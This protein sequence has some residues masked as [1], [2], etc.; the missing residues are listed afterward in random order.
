[1]SE[2]SKP[3]TMSHASG[4][5]MSETTFPP[6]RVPTGD[7]VATMD[8]QPSVA[9]PPFAWIRD[10]ATTDPDRV[11]AVSRVGTTTYGEL[12]AMV[13]RRSAVIDMPSS[14]LM[15]VPVSLDLATVVELMAVVAAGGVAMPYLEEVPAVE[16]IPGAGDV[17]AVPTSGS[18]GA[19]R[20]VRITA[21]NIVAAV[22]ASRT[23]L[24]TDGSDRWL[25]CL[26]L[27]HVG[28]LSILW[29]S[30]EAGGSIA[31]APFDDDLADFITAS[32]PTVASM[33]PTMVRR[34]LAVDAGC[35]SALRFILV[36]GAAVDPGLVDDAQ[37]HGITL[38][39]TYG[40]T[41]A[42]S[43]IA[44]VRPDAP[45]L[46]AMP[47]EGITVSIRHDESSPDAGMAQGL[48]TIEGASVSPG[49]LGE[50]ERIGPFVT[51]DI[52]WIDDA[53][54]LHI[55]GRAD[56]VVISG[57]ENVSLARVSE[58]VRS[59]PGVND[60]VA[61]GL[62]DPEWGSVVVAVVASQLVP[63]ELD[64]ATS[65]KLVPSER[66]RRWVVV[67]EIPLL[68]NGKHDIGAIEAMVAES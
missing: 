51:N 46:A 12:V 23:H 45:T 55:V 15:P 31:I 13:E 53:G 44:T 34:L 61:I 30:F 65:A 68:P 1:M 17:F 18:R 8:S 21:D 49:Y 63:D 32:Q 60:A 64:T 11:A 5:K 56:D 35:L 41:E 40:M 42:T 6:G 66:P 58:V 43:Q 24:G 59:V 9:K 38:L 54:S 67:D 47:L 3:S 19:A 52:G 22:G 57:G 4:S 62:P 25:L 50:P 2:K 48:V 16:G 7:T 33:V 36:G 14:R 10:W 29:R 26:P 28:G 37:R 27:N 20:V 39:G